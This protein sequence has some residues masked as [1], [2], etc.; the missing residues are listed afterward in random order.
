MRARAL[1]GARTCRPVAA[2]VATAP[3]GRFVLMLRLYLPRDE[4]LDGTYEYP[5]IERLDP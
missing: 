4:I 5:P 3:G 2:A 1:A